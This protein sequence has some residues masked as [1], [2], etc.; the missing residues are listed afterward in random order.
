[1]NVKVNKRLNIFISEEQQKKLK[2]LSFY[3]GESIG[4][5]LRKAIDKLSEKV[6]KHE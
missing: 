6:S 2:L 4:S 5:I 1:M 3:S